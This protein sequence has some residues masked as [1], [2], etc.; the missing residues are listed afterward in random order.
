MIHHSDP[1]KVVDGIN[2]AASRAGIAEK[3]ELLPMQ[4]PII[5]DA[6]QKTEAGI[7]A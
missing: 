4:Q 6:G 5:V 2:L 1:K 3:G 7:A